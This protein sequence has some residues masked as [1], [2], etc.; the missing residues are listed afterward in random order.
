METSKPVS[1]G[2]NT[3]AY[4]PQGKKI[5]FDELIGLTRN[6]RPPLFRLLSAIKACKGVLSYYEALKICST[7][8]K[9]SKSKTPLLDELINELIHFDVVSHHADEHFNKYLV[10]NFV[11]APAAPKLIAEHF[12]MM[13]VDTALLYDVLLSLGK[14]N[15]IDNNYIRYRDRRT[16]TKGQDHNNYVW[17]AFSYTKTTGINTVYGNKKTPSNGK[18]ALVVV[19]MVI[20]R[21]YELFD[22][23]G[24]IDRIRVLLNNTVSERKIIP[25][26]VYREISA[27]ALK[28]ARA[29]GMLTYNMA[30]FFGNGIYEVI[31][32]LKLVKL[33][34]N[35]ILDSPTDTVK[36]ISDT[37]DLIDQTGNL[38]NLSNLTGDFFQS[39]MY[40]LFHHLYPNSS[41]EQGKKLPAMDDTVG[42]KKKYEYDFLIQSVN[43]N[44]V[45]AV[46]LKGTMTNYAVPLGDNNKKNTLKWFF[47]RTF[48][49]L[50]LH[51]QHQVFSNTQVKA[52]FITSGRF[53]R[54]GEKY[55][56]ALNQGKLKPQNI[57][58]SYNGKQLLKMVNEESLY[59][60][61]STL[62]KYFIHVE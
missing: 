24:F 9:K 8:L 49:S 11:E 29:F 37:L 3:Y 23:D 17:D 26:I 15:L 41:V 32:N 53:E 47:E 42:R 34:E 4:Y 30:A 43:T 14:F 46:E 27:I 56:A 62:E 21:R 59:T 55:L 48:P 6:R 25:V 20:S 35:A 58:I 22:Y 61:Q 18:Q 44:E 45:I 19:D 13:M 5:I 28:K 10:A 39:L 12:S 31:D 38:Y 1:F 51:Y 40:Q 54:D 16:P 36:T 33:S 50:T 60:L 57:N 2:K 7:P 52:C